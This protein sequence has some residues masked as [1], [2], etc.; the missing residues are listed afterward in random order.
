MPRPRP[1]PQ[2]EIQPEI[3]PE[4]AVPPQWLR[5]AVR[6]ELEPLFAELRRF[7]DRRMA[8]LGAELHATTQLMAFT[9]ATISERL[10][11]LQDHMTAP[12]CLP[13]I[14][15]SAP[16]DPAVLSM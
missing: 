15:E 13:A 12:G 2:P 9:E 8:E 4:P 1:L 11:R 5:D 16:A 14:V 3:Q 10:A 7:V 6:A